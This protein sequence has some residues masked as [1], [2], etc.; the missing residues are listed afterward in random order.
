MKNRGGKGK[1]YYKIN[2][3]K[4][5][6]VGLEFVN[7]NDEV[8]LINSEGVIIRIRIGDISTQSRYATGVKL[9]DLNK[10]VRVVD[11][12]KIADDEIAEQVTFLK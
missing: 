9:I 6:I 11:I 7:N 2:D 8:M 5:D 1:I 3:K 4:G 12:A 10:D